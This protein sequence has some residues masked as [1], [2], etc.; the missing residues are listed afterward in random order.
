MFEQLNRILFHLINQYAGLNPFADAAAIFAAKYMPL[1]I[2]LGLIYLWIKRNDTR[3]VILYGAYAAVLGLLLNFIIGLVYYHPRPFMMHVGTLLFPYSPD[4]SFPSDHTTFM[5][6]AAFMLTY[7]KKTRTPGLILVVLGL[8]GG[9]ARVFCGVHF[10]L[11]ILGSVL[12]ALVISILVY[13][14]R[15]SLKPLNNI[16][17]R[18]YSKLTR[19][20]AR[21]FAIIN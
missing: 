11:D 5:L 18:M 13:Q 7:F 6:S 3:D 17:K 14:F 20:F 9:F 2:I 1:V 21:M 8:I 15:N 12:V 4:S 19:M 16:F 10:P